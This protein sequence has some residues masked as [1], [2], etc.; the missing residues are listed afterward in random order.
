MNMRWVLLTGLATRS[1]M[2]RSAAWC[3]IASACLPAIASAA[4]EVICPD[5]VKVQ[6]SAAAPASGWIV[7]HRDT[8]SRLE[9]IT[10]F[11]GAP[12][13]R[14]SLVYDTWL[15]A[16]DTVTATWS[17]PKDARGYW[18][19]C[20]YEATTVELS[21]PLPATLATCQVIYERQAAGARGLPAIR[22]V[23]CR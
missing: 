10:F 12:A 16:K 20:S 2:L 17:F 18:V 3:A 14:A 21:R 19:S 22:S 11:N 5:S 23:A 4:D 1:H 9:M 15:E 8:A 6:Q 13:E 7:S